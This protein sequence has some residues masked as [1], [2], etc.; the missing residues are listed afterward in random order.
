MTNIL[1][2]DAERCSRLAVSRRP[3]RNPNAHGDTAPWLQLYRSQLPHSSPGRVVRS[4]VSQRRQ[5]FAVFPNQPRQFKSA[6]QARNEMAGLRDHP[7]QPAEE[8]AVRPIG[9]CSLLADYEA[10]RGADAMN[11]RSIR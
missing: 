4:F 5:I 3:R 8:E 6:H 10:E 7:K 1:R 9:N 2:S 11:R